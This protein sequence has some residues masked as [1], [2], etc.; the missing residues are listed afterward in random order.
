M[1]G[2]IRRS[3]QANLLIKRHGDGA[4][5]IAAQ[6]ADDLLSEGDIPGFHAWQRIVAAICELSRE[7]PDDGEQVN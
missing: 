5:L 4:T 3:H 1:S 6:R 2:S 7:K